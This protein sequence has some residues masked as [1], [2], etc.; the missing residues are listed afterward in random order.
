MDISCFDN[1]KDG[2]YNLPDIP[3]DIQKEFV[4]K[5]NKWIEENSDM[6]DESKLE[7]HIDR[8]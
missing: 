3:E 5:V 7:A 4:E 2:E 6:L 1:E 8:T